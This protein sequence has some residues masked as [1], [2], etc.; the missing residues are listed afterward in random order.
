MPNLL[1]RS[2]VPT[3]FESDVPTL[4]SESDVTTFV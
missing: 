2:D 4:L 1:S 3:L